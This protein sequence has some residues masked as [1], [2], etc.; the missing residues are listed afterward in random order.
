MRLA[1]ANLLL[2]S[3]RHRRCA[4]QRLPGRPRRRKTRR[5]KLL[6]RYL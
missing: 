6:L 2:K 3:L 5:I 1:G 4:W